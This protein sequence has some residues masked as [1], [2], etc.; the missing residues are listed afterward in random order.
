MPDTALVISSYTPTVRAL[1]HSRASRPDTALPASLVVPVPDLPGAELPGVTVETAAIAAMIPGTHVLAQPTRTDVLAALPAYR[2]VHFSGQGYAD[3]TEP[4]RSHLILT[5]HATTPL[6]V[7]DITALNLD[8]DL[9]YLS[10]C[11]TALAPPRLADESFHFTGAFYLAGYR[12]VVGALW[13]INDDAAAK[14]AE[15]FYSH[16]TNHGTTP[17]SSDLAAHALHRATTRLRTQYPMAPTLWAAHT[18]TGR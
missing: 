18:H 5:D 3:W 8:A 14:F 15:D 12:H 7:A 10:A 1:G 2:I 4:T 13:P 17:P 16:L 11:G 6:T 9:A